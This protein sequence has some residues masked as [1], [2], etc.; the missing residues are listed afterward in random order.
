MTTSVGANARRQQEPMKT[1]QGQ[2]SAAAEQE[3]KGFV[4]RALGPILEH[5]PPSIQQTL[6]SRFCAEYLA[7]ATA[8][9]ELLLQKRL[10]DDEVRH[11]LF[12]PQ[13]RQY[14]QY[15]VLLAVDGAAAPSN[16]TAQAW[17]MLKKRFMTMFYLK[18][19]QNWPL[20]VEFLLRGGLQILV[21]SFLDDDLQTRG[22]AIDSF[23]QITG[24]AA[25]DWFADP[26]GYDAKV[27]HS[28]MIA[29]A[30]PSAGFLRAILTN[31]ELYGKP[32]STSAAA[33]GD[34]TAD[35]IDSGNETVP[36]AQR[37]PGGTF[38]ML[39]ILAFFLSWVRKFYTNNELRLSRELLDL[40]QHWPERTRSEEPEELK[41][42]QQLYDDFSRWSAIEDSKEAN[43]K[44]QETAAAPIISTGDAGNENRQQSYF[45]KDNV[46]SLLQKASTSDHCDSAFEEAIKLCSMAIDANVG[47]LDARLLRATAL[48]MQLRIQA[49]TSKTGFVDSENAN[50]CLDDCRAMLGLETSNVDAIRIQVEVLRLMRLW[51]DA[52]D[53]LDSLLTDVDVNDK[54]RC[55]DIAYFQTVRDEAQQEREALEALEA[56]QARKNKIR[57]AK[58]E[59]IFQALLLQQQPEDVRDV[60][61]TV[62]DV[63]LGSPDTPSPQTQ[64]IEDS[65]STSMSSNSDILRRFTARTAKTSAARKGRSTK[66]IQ[67]EPVKAITRAQAFLKRFYRAKQ[68]ATQLWNLVSTCEL[69]ELA[70]AINTSLPEDC[71]PIILQAIETAAVR[72]LS[73]TEQARAVRV[74][75]LVQ[76]APR[77]VFYRD[78]A[79][80]DVQ[81]SLGASLVAIEE[82][83]QRL[84]AS[85]LAA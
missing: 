17:T 51:A 5:F 77:F 45:S 69:G 32:D 67:D 64:P 11:W 81:R 37:L 43:P 82:I 29:L 62:N 80:V 34:G 33:Q 9:L 30:A 79:T 58:E 10:T 4:D 54:F 31:I 35:D 71:F 15:A 20:V 49:K 44:Q 40:L 84:D 1:K 46:E 26:V 6:R 2:A 28:R 50:R 66:S 12:A 57:Q 63:N 52:V 65:D 76:R 55:E 60:T 41:L 70:D 38:V 47:V 75:Q 24:H 42:A 85:T 27:L 48:L 59:A 36:S 68:D 74:A 39:Q 22:Q 83:R 23:V 53:L 61:P 7:P 13:P 19:A 73:N 3:A 78:L 25:F 18:H 16:A 72:A 56:E 21:D 14:T 8:E